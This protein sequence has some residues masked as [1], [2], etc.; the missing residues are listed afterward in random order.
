VKKLNELTL[1][2]MANLPLIMFATLVALSLGA[3]AMGKAPPP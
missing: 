1:F 2:A 3:C